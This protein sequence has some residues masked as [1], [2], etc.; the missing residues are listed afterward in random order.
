MVIQA[1][2]FFILLER[3][4]TRVKRTNYF[5]VIQLVHTQLDSSEEMT[6]LNVS[7][8]MVQQQWMIA[9]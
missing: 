7:V 6:Q 4:L 3:N 1:H 5:F 2:S 8:R 9:V